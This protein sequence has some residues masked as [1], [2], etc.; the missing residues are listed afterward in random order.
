[1]NFV[2]FFPLLWIPCTSH[3]YEFV[4]PHRPSL[5]V[6]T[7]SHNMS[8]SLLW[9]PWTSRR[10]EF[11][12]LH[13]PSL[14]FLDTEPS[15]NAG[16]TAQTGVGSLH[17]KIPAT[18]SWSLSLGRLMTWRG[19]Q[20]CPM[21]LSQSAWTPCFSSQRT[22]KTHT[23]PYGTQHVDTPPC[24]AL[25]ASPDATCRARSLDGQLASVPTGS[26]TA[27]SHAHRSSKTRPLSAF[28][29]MDHST[30][31]S[32]NTTSPITRANVRLRQSQAVLLGL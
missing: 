29:Q 9:I 16:K 10:H 21:H 24:P 28:A 17:I 25:S 3:L 8:V 12:L 5:F 23:S 1:M 7:Q 14:Y 4:L 30:L 26:T 6:S 27:D 19:S 13:R 18:A 15:M 11:V 20:T 2:Q 32:Q 22:S 31:T